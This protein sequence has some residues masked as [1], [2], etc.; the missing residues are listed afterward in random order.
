MYDRRE[1]PLAEYSEES[2]DTLFFAEKAV[3]MLKEIG[4]ELPLEGHR[5]EVWKSKGRQ[6]KRHFAM[7]VLFYR[8][9]SFGV[10]TIEDCEPFGSHS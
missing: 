7:R 8:T 1:G 3:D 10:Y 4:V 5:N 6:L 2:V 9:Y